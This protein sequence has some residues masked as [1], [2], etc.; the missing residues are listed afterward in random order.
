[1]AELGSSQKLLYAFVTLIVGALLVGVVASSA[2]DV[3]D[4]AYATETINLAS[5]RQ[6]DY[7]IADNSSA[8]NFTVTN[9]PTTWKIADCPITNFVYNNGTTA[10]VLDTDYTF[11]TTT[12]RLHVINTTRTSRNNVNATTAY[13]NYCSDDY[14]NSTWSRSALNLVG[15]FFALALLMV[16]VGLFFSVY[17][18]QFG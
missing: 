11:S 16:S 6:N 4:K 5:A 1:M 2:I 14:M 13:Y 18:E 8:S 15:G 3:T 7:N 10:F 9:V 12:G 17:K